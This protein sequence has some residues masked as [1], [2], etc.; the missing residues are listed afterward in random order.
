MSRA[1]RL[2]RVE[3]LDNAIE[4]RFSD[5]HRLPIVRVI[6]QT[7]DQAEQLRK[8]E[9]GKWQKESEPPTAVSFEEYAAQATP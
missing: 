1:N 3:R 9:R 4:T 8:I 5:K 2:A 6:V 7:R